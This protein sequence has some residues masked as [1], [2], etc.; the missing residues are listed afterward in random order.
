MAVLPAANAKALHVVELPLFGTKP[1]LM[2][3]VLA[4]GG[5]AMFDVETPM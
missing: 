1:P 3:V 4:P 5:M 2:A